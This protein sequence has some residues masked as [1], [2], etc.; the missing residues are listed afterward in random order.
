MRRRPCRTV[1]SATSARRGRR[2]TDFGSVH[3]VHAV[4]GPAQPVLRR[5]TGLGSKRTGECQ[6][7][8]RRWGRRCGAQVVCAR[9]KGTRQLRVDGDARCAVAVAGERARAPADERQVHPG[10][11]SARGSLDA[12]LEMAHQIRPR[13]PRR[14]R[15]RTRWCIPATAAASPGHI[16]EGT[17]AR[18]QSGARVPRPTPRRGRR[19]RRTEQWGHTKPLMFSMT[20]RIGMSAFRQNVSSL[21]TS[22][23]ETACVRAARIQTA[24]T[25]AVRQARS[26]C[27]AASTGHALACGVVTRMAPSGLQSRR[28]STTLTC[29][30]EVPATVPARPA[31]WPRPQ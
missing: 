19:R 26:L 18:A 17:H 14:R 10:G 25:G 29:S 2:R 13:A 20:P 6:E 9:L 21:R 5:R 22:F 3:N 24:I 28:N 30:S 27:P 12:Y 11:A 15:W 4:D 16:H 31:S 7:R 23:S 8:L 1:A